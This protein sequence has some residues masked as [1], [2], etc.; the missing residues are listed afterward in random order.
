MVL[1]GIAMVLKEPYMSLFFDCMACIFD[2]NGSNGL[3]RKQDPLL[4]T[5]QM[6]YQSKNGCF[7]QGE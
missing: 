7:V 5:V 4:F 1:K 3:E 6:P 2:K